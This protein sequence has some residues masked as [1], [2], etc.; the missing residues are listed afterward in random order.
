MPA[1]TRADYVAVPSTDWRRSREFYVETLGL[2][3]DEHGQ[4]E[5]WVGEQ[6]FAIWEPASFGMEFAPQKN[7]HTSRSTSTTSPRRVP[8]SRR[9][10]S[11]SSARRWIPGSAT[12]PSSDPD[13]NDLM[14]HSR[15]APH[16]G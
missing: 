5:F 15:Y 9:R 8:S 4:A 3:P 6:C 14:L 11:S 1:I 12:W 16:E 13:G 2:Q 7:A 10:A